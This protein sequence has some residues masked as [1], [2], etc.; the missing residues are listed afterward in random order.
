MSLIVKALATCRTLVLIGMGIGVASELLRIPTLPFAIGLYL[1]FST[2]TAMF[3]GGGVAWL[4][5]RGA[6]TKAGAASRIERGVLISSGLVAG[7]AS[8]GLATIGLIEVARIDWSVEPFLAGIPWQL[9][10]LA[11]FLALAY[12]LYRTARAEAAP[13]P[14]RS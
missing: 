14:D 11:V 10:S 8:I 9:Y 13:V 4:L 3:V 12:W 6:R 7:D 5:A 1:P 2:S